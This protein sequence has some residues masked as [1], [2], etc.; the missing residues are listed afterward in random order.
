MAKADTYEEF[1]EILISPREPYDK[2]TV[3]IHPTE[4]NVEINIWYKNKW[5][6]ISQTKDT[7][8]SDE[9]K[10]QIEIINNNL[11][12]L[13]MKILRKY[14]GRFTSDTNIIRDR[15]KALEEQM[16][17]LED[18]FSKLNKKYSMIKYGK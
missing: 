9:S 15:Q 18:K 14:Y 7:G 16:I 4:D 8:L 1:S 5:K 3:W 11:R 10:N 17:K 2:K 13:L 6:T 12:E